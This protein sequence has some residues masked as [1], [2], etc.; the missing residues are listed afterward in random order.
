VT[1]R[2]V[3]SSI[4]YFS[5]LENIKIVVSFCVRKKLPDLGNNSQEQSTKN[6]KKQYLNF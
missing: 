6:N 2:A 3:S 1:T 4:E 5:P